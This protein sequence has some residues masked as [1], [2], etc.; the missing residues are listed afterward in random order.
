[1]KNS[2]ATGSQ[3][4]GLCNRLDIFSLTEIIN[5]VYF[6]GMTQKDL[7]NPS[8]EF[9]SLGNFR[10]LGEFLKACRGQTDLGQAE[11]A[12]EVGIEQQTYGRWEGGISLPGDVN[13]LIA[14]MRVMARAMD[15]ELGPLQ[16]EALRLFEVDLPKPRKDLRQGVVGKPRGLNVK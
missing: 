6:R 3:G 9:N 2:A 12:K 1:M 16:D 7:L 15:Q 8:L 4:D 5:L 10:T 11:I 14:V 13:D